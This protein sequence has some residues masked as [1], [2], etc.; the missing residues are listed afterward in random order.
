MTETRNLHK[1]QFNQQ[2]LIRRLSYFTI[3]LRE[4]RYSIKEEALVALHSLRLISLDKRS[5]ELHKRDGRALSQ[6]QVTHMGIQTRDKYLRRETSAQYLVEGHKRIYIATCKEL[7]G[8]REVSVVVEDVE[9]SCHILIVE[10]L[11]AKRHR[12][13]E[14]RER[15]THT[16]IGLMSNE[17]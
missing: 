10:L 2:S 8:N 16:T 13:V 3:C 6:E 9:R 14:H 1:S 12:L 17:V 15:I 5:G 11:T 7:L 4:Q